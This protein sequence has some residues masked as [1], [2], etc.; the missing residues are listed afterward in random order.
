MKPLGH[1]ALN[2]GGDRPVMLSS[3][4][5]QI[6]QLVGRQPQIEHR[7]PHPADV[8]ATWANIDKARRLLEWSPEVF[9]EDGLQR[10]VEWYRK[11]REFVL[12]LELDSVAKRIRVYGSRKF[13]EKC[14][15]KM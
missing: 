5:D 9:V 12:P 3:I 1:E 6:A 15:S 13:P 11:N 7:P 4:I 2:L 14:S 8:S 10:S